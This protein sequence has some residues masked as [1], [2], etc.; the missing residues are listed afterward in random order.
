LSDD[1]IKAKVK[2][3]EQYAD[4]DKKRKE[5]IEAKNRAETLVYE[6]DKV[7]KELEGK[8]DEDEKSRVIAAKDDLA[9]AIQNGTVDEINQKTEA[10]TN[11]F[12]ALSQKL[13]SQA[14]PGAGEGGPADQGYASQDFGGQAYEQNQ[15]S[16]PAPD[17]VV[18]VDY[19]VVDEDK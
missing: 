5:E 15:E 8:I 12:H 6:T 10:L 3:A 2:E 9:G 4:E 14:Q 18:D 16:G 7:L 13:Y 11:E 17:N 1:E 19:E